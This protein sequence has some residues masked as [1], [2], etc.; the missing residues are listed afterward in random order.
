MRIVIDYRPALRTRTGVGEYVHQLARAL[1]RLFAG[2]RL[3]LFSSSWSDRFDATLASAIPGAR[4]SDH[5]VPVRVLNLLWHRAEWPQVE[6]FVGEECDVAFSPHPLLLPSRAAQVVMVHDLDFLTHPERTQR[7]IRRDYPRLA[8][9][10]ARRADAVIVP[11]AYTASQ[12]AQRLQVEP[13]RIAVCPPGLPAWRESPRGFARDGYLLF[14]GTAEPRKN[15]EGLLRAY[16][17]L[18]DGWRDAPRLV[19]AGK[20]AADAGHLIER[21]QRALPAGRIEQLGYVA[22]SARQEVYAGARALVLPSF[23]EGFGMPALEAMSLGIPVVVSDR[24]ALPEVVG[25]AGLLIDPTNDQSLSD[26][27]MR[28]LSDDRLAESLSSRG[29]ERA[30][31]FSWER[32]A[33][34]VHAAFSEAIRRRASRTQ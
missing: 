17:R 21:V 9:Q 25:D 22:E 6:R 11:S 26:S 3:T 15:I 14:M 34:L 18:V 7:E 16:Q 10:H 30:A 20:P 4:L 24:G 27:L 12:V 5:Q 2:D 31:R 13:E 23:D 32:T 8:G 29:R 28:V 1:G 33:S 19:L